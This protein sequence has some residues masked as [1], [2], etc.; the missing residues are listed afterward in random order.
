[1]SVGSPEVVHSKTGQRMSGYIS[2]RLVSNN[3]SGNAT[4]IHFFAFEIF[5]RKIKRTFEYFEHSEINQN[6]LSTW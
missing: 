4:H 1:M 2:D 6:C 5:K 3:F